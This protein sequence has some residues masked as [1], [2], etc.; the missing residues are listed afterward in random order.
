MEVRAKVGL[1]IVMVFVGYR[2]GMSAADSE[3]DWKSV[4]SG[5]LGLTT[6]A[7][8]RILGLGIDYSGS[9]EDCLLDFEWMTEIGRWQAWHAAT[10]SSV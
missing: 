6:A 3:D 8:A 1:C 2:M 9:L 10:S 7:E 5:S 4:S